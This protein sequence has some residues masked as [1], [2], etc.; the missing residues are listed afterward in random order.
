MNKA[1]LTKLMKLHVTR[2]V[3]FVKGI[4]SFTFM[5]WIIH[6]GLATPVALMGNLIWLWLVPELDMKALR[7]MVSSVVR[8]IHEIEADALDPGKGDA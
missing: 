5:A 1:A 6:P 3:L 8:E 7:E 2:R 4:V